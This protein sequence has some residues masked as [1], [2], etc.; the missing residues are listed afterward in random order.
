MPIAIMNA[1]NDSGNLLK[2]A[3]RSCTR[4]ASAVAELTAEC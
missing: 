1:T 4:R 3:R 2:G